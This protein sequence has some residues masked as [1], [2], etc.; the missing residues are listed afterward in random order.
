MARLQWNPIV[1][2]DIGSEALRAQQA[3]GSSIQGA[4]GGLS[5]MLNDWEA[6]R[7]RDEMGQLIARQEAFVGQDSARY[8]AARRDGSLTQGFTYLRPEQLA[9]AVRTFGA[10]LERDFRGDQAYADGR[11]DRT[12]MLGERERA[13]TERTA[14]LAVQRG[15][16]LLEGQLGTGEI[17][18]EQYNERAAPLLAQAA[19]AAQIGDIGA[20]RQR[21]V[22]EYRAGVAYADGRQDRSWMVEDREDNRTA[23]AL[24]DQLIRNDGSIQDLEAMPDYQAA[25]VQA[26]LAARNLAGQ[27][28]GQSSAGSNDQGGAPA[29]ASGPLSFSGLQS[30]ETEVAQVFANSQASPAVIAGILGNFAVEGGYGGALGD[31]GTASGIAQWRKGRRAAFRSR[32]NGLDPHEASPAAQARHVI[33]ELTT[34]E[35][36]RSADISEDNAQAILNAQTPGQAAALFDQH[37]ERSDGRHRARRVREAE[38]YA[39]RISPA[40]VQGQANDVSVGAAIAS[41]SDRYGP[42]ARN[43]IPA[44][45]DDRDPL[46]VSRELTAQD[47][48]KFSGLNENEV[49]RRIRRV[50]DLYRAENGGEG[51]L[52]AAA[53]AQILANN[54]NPYTVG[55]FFGGFVGRRGSI[56]TAPGSL[57]N[58][59]IDIQ[60]VKNDLRQLVPTARRDAN[61]R[62]V[63][64]NGVV[65]TE[66]PLARHYNN[67]QNRTAII[68]GAPAGRALLLAK[69]AELETRR[70]RDLQLN[71]VDN[72]VT[73]RLALEVDALQE[74]WGSF[75]GNSVDQLAAAGFANSPPP[76]TPVGRG[77]ASAPV[78]RRLVTPTPIYGD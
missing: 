37:F 8:D 66:I 6:A 40:T 51:R 53:A 68:E 35:G 43:V 67:Q 50:Q 13:T 3:A 1:A 42:L 11:V 76:R 17:T 28:G 9:G 56:G 55:D 5:S 25:S 36:R 29:G 38:R 77:P 2:P 70:A 12:F 52:S 24:V 74:Q 41:G 19:T 48:G 69:T 60:G 59:S 75:V 57:P 44:M 58:Q 31:G 18:R 23:Q 39:T 34:V 10:D 63:V 15:L 30:A 33:W 27:V 71:N 65:Q 78:R 20:G 46:T 7:Q 21:G 45:N 16:Y 26:R 32:N 22:G 47:D 73:E 72:P 14:G 64:V 4:F 61:G 62:E 49:A 54:L